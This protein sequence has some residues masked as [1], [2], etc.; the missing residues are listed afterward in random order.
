MLFDSNGGASYTSPFSSGPLSP[1]YGKRIG[2]AYP[3][4]MK[5]EDL[6]TTG[7]ETD[8]IVLSGQ[9]IRNRRPRTESVGPNN[10]LCPETQAKG[11]GVQPDARRNGGAADDQRR[12]VLNAKRQAGNPAFAEPKGQ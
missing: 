3:L 11:W 4:F 6:V 2:P 9:P 1:P 7:E 12:R 5:F 10:L 8:G